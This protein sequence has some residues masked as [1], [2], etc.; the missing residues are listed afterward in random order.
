MQSDE[1]EIRQLVDTWMTAS[2]TGD[3]ETVLS[4]MSDDVVFLQPGQLPMRKVDFAAAA[5]AQSGQEAPRIEGTSEI[6]EIQ[7]VGEWAF[8][9]T[10]LTVTVTPPGGSPSITRA[11]HT[12][13]ILKKEKGK[14]VL[15]RDA[16]LLSP[17]SK[18][19]T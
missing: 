8:M 14:W 17:V 6:Q 11:G 4:L 12:L 10:K 7:V 1:Q 3:V 13:S 16:N 15:A 5:Q 18:P 19:E 9:W 2:K